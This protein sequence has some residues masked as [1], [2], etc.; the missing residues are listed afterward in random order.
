MTRWL[1]WGFSTLLLVSLTAN[2]VI[3]YYLIELREDDRSIE[4][5][6]SETESDADEAVGELDTFRNVL[7]AFQDTP[8]FDPS[9]IEQRIRELRTDVDDL[10]DSVGGLFKIAQDL[11][12]VSTAPT[13][14][15]A[16]NI[17]KPYFCYRGDPAYW[18]F[19]GLSC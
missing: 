8:T 19:N 14:V 12:D 2:G 13:I 18:D 10:N 17:K 5:R 15:D 3:G 4:A 9:T 11:A 6:L 1:V 16:R 7:A